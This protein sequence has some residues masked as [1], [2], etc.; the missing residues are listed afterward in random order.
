MVGFLSACDLVITIQDTASTQVTEVSPTDAVTQDVTPKSESKSIVP[1][2]DEDSNA[3]QEQP[4]KSSEPMPTTE[5]LTQ[6]K[7]E[8]IY[9]QYMESA[10]W[11]N[12]YEPQDEFEPAD[13]TDYTI[14]AYRIFDLD[15]NGIPELWFCAEAPDT[16]AGPR[17]PERRDFFCAIE[18]SLVKQ[19]LSGY[20]S[21]GTM[22]GDEI[23]V[24]YDTEKQNHVICKTGY[25]GGF[26]GVMSWLEI[27]DFSG[28]SI[29]KTMQ[30]SQI[31][32]TASN[33]SDGELDKPDL[34]YPF[35]DITWGNEAAY[36]V[37]RIN[38]GQ[39]SKEAY[40]QLSDRFIN[41]V[42]ES[43]RY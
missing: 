5:T 7:Y 43:F 36:T 22:G 17:G 18:D 32:Q 38:G 20:I 2:S 12:D 40:E 25:A 37:Y 10:Q 9:L 31:S 3:K 15:G 29:V 23:T 30:Y 35:T 11:K 41:P 27:Y 13:M 28:L 42:D 4:L 16:F 1:A 24:K 6:E 33:Y 34:Y 19:L 8:K 26:G 39:V 14:T 21:G